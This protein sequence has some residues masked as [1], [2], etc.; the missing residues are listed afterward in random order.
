MDTI[1]NSLVGARSETSKKVGRY[2]RLLVGQVVYIVFS[3]IAFQLYLI[4]ESHESFLVLTSSFALVGMAATWLMYSMIRNFSTDQR[5]IR[6]TFALF[7]IS[8]WTGIIAVN[9]LYPLPFDSLLY[10]WLVIVNQFGSLTAFVIILVLMI[11]DIFTASHTIGYRLLG[12]ACIYFNIGV[13]F[14]F[15][16]AAINLLIPNAMGLNMPAEFISY[17]HCTNYSYYVLA[18]IDTPYHVNGVIGAVAVI[19]S[20]FANLYIVLLIGRILIK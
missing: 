7:F 11:R 12:A 13:V 9:S 18:G 19:E 2:T 10:Y 14:S 16:Y 8:F 5:F 6:L 4:H 3:L 17:M 1:H 15:A 20:L